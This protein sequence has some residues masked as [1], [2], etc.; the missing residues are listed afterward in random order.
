MPIT[1]KTRELEDADG[2]EHV[3]SIL[4]H[5][6]EEA[7]ELLPKVVRILG[8]VS[9]PLINA[10]P[11]GQEAPSDV[12]NMT[13]LGASVAGDVDGEQLS[14]ALVALANEFVAAGGAKFCKELLKYTTRRTPGVEG[15]QKVAV[16]FGK[17]YQANFG[18]LAKAV[19]FAVEI[20][21]APSLRDKLG[22]GGSLEKMLS[23]VKRSV[24]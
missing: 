10:L 5:P 19:L 12:T 21:F 6:A 14:K 8:E 20:N 18:E 11:R 4:P 15:E 17:V 13:E 7:L 2:V 9:G 22:S 1:P 3:Y 23:L 24:S 16:E